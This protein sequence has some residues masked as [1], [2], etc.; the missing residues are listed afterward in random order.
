VSTD[1][2][3]TFEQLLGGAAEDGAENGAQ[4]GGPQGG[5]RER[6]TGGPQAGAQRAAQAAAEPTSLPTFRKYKATKQIYR[7]RAI[8]IH[9]YIGPNGSGKSLAMVRDT[10]PS[11]DSGR[12][13]L[14][15]VMLLD[16]ATG[17]PHPNYE[18]LTEWSQLLDPDLAHAD[19]LFDEVTGIA[20][21]R[22]AMGMPVPVQNLLN[23]LRRRDLT[24]R[25]TAPAWNRADTIIRSCTQAVTLARGFWK[26][27]VKVDGPLQEQKL[28]APNRIFKLRTFSAIDFDEWT[29]SKASQDSKGKAIKPMRPDVVEWFYGPQSRAF[30]A[31]DTLD[32]VSRVGEVLDSGRCA[33]CGGKR[34]IPNCKCEPTVDKARAYKPGSGRRVAGRVPVPAVLEQQHEHE[35]AHA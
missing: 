21:S 29:S 25:W 30:A 7:R 19:I 35:H 27:S 11:L 4:D 26:A 1:T 32:S 16:T 14:S 2:S 20:G 12:R 8:P 24:L 3:I 23:Q 17:Q 33:H 13:V 5:A 34:V 31:Y 22:E 6:P 15:T 9:A 28:W 18:R 10:I